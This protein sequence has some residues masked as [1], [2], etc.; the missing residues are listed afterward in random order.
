MISF[1]CLAIATFVISHPLPRSGAIFQ[2][3]R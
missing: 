1:P 2:P 3:T